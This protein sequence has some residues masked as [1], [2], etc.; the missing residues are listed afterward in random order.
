MLPVRKC[1]DIVSLGEVLTPII[2]LKHLH[3]QLGGGQILLKDEGR[4]PTAS[5]KARSPVSLCRWRMH[6]A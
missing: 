5:F 1:C 4:L 2:A 6:W 3:G